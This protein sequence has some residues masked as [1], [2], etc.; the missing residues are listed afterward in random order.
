MAPVPGE[1]SQAL[2]WSPG[3][4]KNWFFLTIYKIIY[5]IIEDI[6]PLQRDSL[7]VDKQ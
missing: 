2:L 5:E 3:T 7:G 1:K 4:R 6:Y